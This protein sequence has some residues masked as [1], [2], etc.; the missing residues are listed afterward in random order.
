[1]KTRIRVL[2]FC[3]LSVAVVAPARAQF[4][5]SKSDT[6]AAS[7]TTRI[8][9]GVD[10]SGRLG[11]KASTGTFSKF[12]LYSEVQAATG[13]A[14]TTVNGISGP[15]VVLT[16]SDITEGT[17]L[18]WTT[19]R[20][21]ARYPLLSGSYTNPSW[22]ASIPFSKLTATP[23]T[24]SGYGITDGVSTGGSYAN[25]TWLTSLAWSK[26]TGTP[27]TRS[28]YGITD[29]EGTITAGTT[30]Q[31]YRGDKTFV[32][33]NTAAVTESTNLYY[34]DTRAR[35]AL[36][37]TAP[38]VYNSGTGAFSMPAA[39][40]S[41][42]GYLT[43]SNFSTFNS[44]ANAATT[45]SGY[46]ITDAYPYQEVATYAAMDALTFSANTGKWVLVTADERYGLSKQW[47][48]VWADGSAV[49]HSNKYAT[50]TEK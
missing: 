42:D 9:L 7:R 8:R 44:K 49:M 32:T 30:T 13:G 18:Y 21:D 11:Q 27:T 25:P 38:L 23:T 20:G 19:A 6:A 47:Y 26:I 2:L 16:T 46:G 5:I 3:L 33:L 50:I 12:A 28:G 31:Y 39:T 45:L 37:A 36:S 43:A 15:T 1:M 14:V 17:N 4:E 29:A 41:V 10:N 24:L 48:F 22:I 35:G 40:S 34:T